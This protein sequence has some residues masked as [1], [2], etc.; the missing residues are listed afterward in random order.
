MAI[1]RGLKQLE[2]LSF[3]E[4]HIVELPREIEQLTQLKLLDLS[5]CS[6]LKVIPTNVLSKLSLLEALYIKNN[7]VEW[8]ANEKNSQGNLSL[9]EL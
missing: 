5:N 3:A 2:V 8:E 4:S 1:I 9:V 6:K 7:F